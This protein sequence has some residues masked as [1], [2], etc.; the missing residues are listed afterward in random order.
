MIFA[1]TDPINLDPTPMLGSVT[2]KRYPVPF[3]AVEAGE[4]AYQLPRPEYDSP[5]AHTANPLLTNLRRYREHWTPEDAWIS[6]TDMNADSDG[7]KLTPE[8]AHH[9]DRVLRRWLSIFEGV[10]VDDL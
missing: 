8:Q 2:G 5:R 10:N 6:I 9:G 4:S 3:S 1:S 7:W